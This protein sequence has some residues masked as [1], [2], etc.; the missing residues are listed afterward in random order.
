MFKTL[1]R[2]PSVYSSSPHLWCSGGA[3]S[4]P[5]FAKWRRNPRIWPTQAHT[6]EILQL[7][8]FKYFSRKVRSLSSDIRNEG[9][10]WQ[11]K[12]SP[13]TQAGLAHYVGTRIW[14]TPAAAIQNPGPP[15]V[16]NPHPARNACVHM[17]KHTQNFV[18]LLPFPTYISSI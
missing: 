2:I 17:H 7:C 12:L 5:S 1:G 9:N 18:L 11:L 6:E 10:S 4:Q 13:R 8:S 16:Y 3:G 14:T 15:R